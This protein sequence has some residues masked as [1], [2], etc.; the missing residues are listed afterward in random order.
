MTS[1]PQRATGQY[2]ITYKYANVKSQCSPKSN[3]HLRHPPRGVTV[4]DLALLI[5]LACHLGVPESSIQAKIIAERVVAKIIAE[6]VVANRVV[7]TV[8]ATALPN[9]PDAPP[10]PT[11]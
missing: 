2:S 6:R 9:N 4:G 5:L 7:S 11:R 8:T 1:H 10:V 3:G